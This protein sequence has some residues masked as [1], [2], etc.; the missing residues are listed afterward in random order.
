M[1]LVQESHRERQ[2]LWALQLPA[3]VHERIHVLADFLDIVGRP[4][5]GPTLGAGLER[6]Q[7]HKHRLRALD[8]RRQDRFFPNEGIFTN[9][10]AK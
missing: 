6:Q 9:G 10:R 3:R 4:R 7:V 2:P 5:R 8:L 1:G